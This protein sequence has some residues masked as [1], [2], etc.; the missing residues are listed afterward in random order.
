MLSLV[1]KVVSSRGSVDYLLTTLPGVLISFC[2]CRRLAGTCC[3]EHLVYLVNP[4]LQIKV[5]EG[6]SMCVVT[7]SAEPH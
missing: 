3:F 6:A 2:R 1:S 5:L 4:T 7:R